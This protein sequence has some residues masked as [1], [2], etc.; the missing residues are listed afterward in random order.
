MSGGGPYALAC[1][2]RLPERIPIVG[3]VSGMV[4]L[5]DP[6][7]AAALPSRARLAFALLRRA[8]WPARAL[9]AVAI[10]AA[11]RCPD[12]TFDRI[13]A[14]APAPDRALLRQP[15]I[16][17][18]LIADVREALSAGGHGAIHELALFGRPWGFRLADVQV[19]VVLWHGEAD[20]QVPAA[21]ARGLARGLPDCRAR[22]LADAGHFWLLDHY[23][24]VLATLCPE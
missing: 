1:A 12:P 13:A 18:G 17:A 10:V 11:R 20:A 23:E 4:P 16:R 7:A 3:I 6:D 5:D 2:W 19:P 22:F 8:Q 9:A 14:R 21:F 15:E 24:E